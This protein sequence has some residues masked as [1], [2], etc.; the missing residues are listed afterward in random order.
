MKWT[1]VIFIT[2]CKH[3]LYTNGVAPHTNTWNWSMNACGVNVC[4][5]VHR[6]HASIK[7][8]GRSLEVFTSVC[9][10]V[11]CGST[12]FSRQELR[13]LTCTSVRV[14]SHSLWA[15]WRS[16]VCLVCIHVFCRSAFGH[17]LH[18][19]DMTNNAY[20]YECESFA[21]ANINCWCVFQCLGNCSILIL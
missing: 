2:T 19:A 15:F 17:L 7:R 11:R 16:C 6:E 3:K 5:V 4:F 12:H 10:C 9:V 20:E 8:R 21:Y 1:P 18:V 14:W 13:S